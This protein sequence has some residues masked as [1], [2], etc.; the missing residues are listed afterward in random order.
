MGKEGE[1]SGGPQASPM[2]AALL[3]AE[4]AHEQA[5]ASARAE[6]ERI[7]AG[8]RDQVRRE[9]DALARDLDQLQRGVRERLAAARSQELASLAN[10]SSARSVAFTRLSRERAAALAE[11][12]VG[13][14]LKDGAP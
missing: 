11:D 1:G 3:E 12:V 14:L 6:A 2:L 10:E 9:D 8:A 4:A 13:H 5:L 7:I